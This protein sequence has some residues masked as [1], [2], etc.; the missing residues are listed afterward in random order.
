MLRAG[1]VK[2]MD[3]CGAAKDRK[4][5]PGRERRAA[6]DRTIERGSR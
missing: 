6:E 2:L 3:C 5:L 4:L 1:L